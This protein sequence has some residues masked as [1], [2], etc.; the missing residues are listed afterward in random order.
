MSTQV[1]NGR[2]ASPAPDKRPKK[3]MDVVI[4]HGPDGQVFE[5]PLAEA[6]KY[7]MSAARQKE[8]TCVTV[9]KAD[10]GEVGGRHAVL[11]VD[12][13]V[14]YHS[15]WLY[16]PYLWWRNL[17]YYTGWHWHPNRYNPVAYDN[18]DY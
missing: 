4:A 14:G 1:G 12:G 10:E 8:L 18:D 15:N 7:A 13:S 16:G 3:A 6:R 11:L 5:I 17:N 2:P 9:P